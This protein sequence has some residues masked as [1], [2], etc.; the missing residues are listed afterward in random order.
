[1]CHVGGVQKWRRRGWLVVF[2]SVSEMSCV[3]LYRRS[4][5]PCRG[6]WARGRWS[7]IS[8]QQTAL[9]HH[10]RP[11]MGRV[12]VGGRVNSVLASTN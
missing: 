6:G 10:E 1:M 3:L 5:C 7:H 4:G 11:H 9:A 12:W 2:K 8:S